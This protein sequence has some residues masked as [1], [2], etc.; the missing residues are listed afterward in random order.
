MRRGASI[1]HIGTMAVLLT[2]S[3]ALATVIM[4]LV[5]ALPVDG[6]RYNA[7]VSYSN[8]TEGD[9]PEWANG[10]VNTQLDCFTDSLIFNTA[11]FKG[12]GNVVED[13]M[14]NYYVQFEGQGIVESYTN[15]FDD[16]VYD[17]AHKVPYPR[18]WHG[19]LAY[20]KPLL[21]FLNTSEIMVLNMVVQFALLLLVAAKM[22][23]KYGPK[24]FIVFLIPVM[25]INPVT[26]AQSLQYSQIYYVILLHMA[27]LV[28]F[29]AALN[30]PT[31]YYLF[32]LNGILVAFLDFLTY[33]IVALGVP[34]IFVLCVDERYDKF[35]ELIKLSAAWGVGYAGMWAGKWVVASVLTGTDVIENAKS[36]IG[37]W[38]EKVSLPYTL[39]LNF[40]PL[41]NGT[42]KLLLVCAIASILI[43]VFVYPKARLS[44]NASKT[45]C[46]LLIGLYSI[47]WYYVMRT[48]SSIH[49]WMTFRN[50]ALPGYAITAVITESLISK[51][52]LLGQTEANHG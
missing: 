24:R 3:I 17:S 46:I 14:L 4:I 42:T 37:T 47:V 36:M 16:N 26:A 38:T 45:L 32:L 23:A 5:Y 20:I 52:R 11:T 1:K 34:L 9:H 44:I 22:V 48:H 30:K 6:M 10:L 40:G 15:S 51:K 41:N 7:W 50:Y 35:V 49:W 21:M 2:A 8:F 39:E 13:A 19:H 28:S 25:V 33:P 29:D 27:I 43:Y 18:Y 31:V 12:T